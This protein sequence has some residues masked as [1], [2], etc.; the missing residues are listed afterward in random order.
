MLAT[1]VYSHTAQYDGAIANYLTS[2]D[3]TRAHGS[4][5]AYPPS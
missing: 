3:A 1:K 2:L 4:R 5:S